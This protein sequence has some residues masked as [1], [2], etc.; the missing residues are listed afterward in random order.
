[1]NSIVYVFFRFVMK[2]FFTINTVN[3]KIDTIK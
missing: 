1:L 2:Y 3:A